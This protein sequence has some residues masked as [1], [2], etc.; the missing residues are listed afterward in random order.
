[1]S[2]ITNIAGYRFVELAD[3]DELLEPFTKLC[4]DLELRGTVL[5]SPNGIN[6]FL[7]G[8]QDSVDSYLEFIEADERFQG[9]DLKVSY[10]F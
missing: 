2:Q 7:A 8:T 4:D 1:M 10:T 3:R 5:L 6:F 9:I